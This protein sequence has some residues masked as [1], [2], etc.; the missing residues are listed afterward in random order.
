LLKFLEAKAIDMVLRNYDVL[1][2]KKI[3]LCDIFS[4]QKLTMNLEELYHLRKDFTIIGLTGRIASGCSTVAD[5]LNSES[6]NLEFPT[7][8]QRDKLIDPEQIKINMCDN[9]LKLNWKGFKTINYEHILFLHLIFESLLEDN[10][11]KEFLSIFFQNGSTTEMGIYDKFENRFD[12]EENHDI[13]SEIT[14]IFAKYN[15]IIEVLKKDISELESKQLHLLLDNKRNFAEYY[16]L[17]FED[18]K[19]FSC[20]FFDLLHRTDITRKTR[21]IHD[22]ANNLRSYKTVKNLVMKQHKP[23]IDNIYTVAITINKIIKICRANNP[24]NCKIVI[25]SLKNSLELSFFKEKFAAFYM[26]AV[27]KNLSERNKN[28]ENII[29]DFGYSEE[30]IKQHLKK[31][32]LLD[33]SEYKGDDVNKGLFPY[34][35]IEN[36][37]QKSDYHI[38]FS[39]ERKGSYEDCE[40]CD[41]VT[42]DSRYKYLNLDVQLMKFIS[43]IHQPG[44]VTPTAIERTMQIAFNAKYNSG[45]ISRQVGAVITDEN[46]SVKSIGWNDVAQGQIPCSLRNINDLLEGKNHHQFSDFEIG[47]YRTE[48][49]DG[50]EESDDLKYKDGETFIEKTRKLVTEES[51]NNLSGRNCSYCFKTFHNSFENEKNQVHTRSLH[52]EE[53]AMMQISKYGGHKLKNGYLFTTA[54]PCELCS[55]KAYQLGIKNI[56]FIDPYPG[57]ASKHT[58]KNGARKD[59]NPNLI[60]FQGALGKTFHKLYEPFM[61]Q[62][63]E[64]SILTSIKPK[65]DIFESIRKLDIEKTKLEQIKQIL[66]S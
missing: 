40:S 14:K 32:L 59:N 52:A 45:C 24:K 46:F 41:N 34:P 2:C 57:I 48:R 16:S 15:S 20:D 1:F 8:I 30:K 61:S 5:T 60:M 39:A 35:D 65:A 49:Q 13:V 43:L 64:L 63:D 58:L 62:K 33:E 17:I 56:Y 51:F 22:L 9:Y 50:L 29:K 11:L 10:F 55:K 66:Q 38:F 6:Y 31:I 4:Q 28:L 25:D 47:K 44:I 42:H 23:N 21:L 26:V 27:K 3:M 18:F 36:C 37:I 19:S 12:P 54:S 7:N 53:N